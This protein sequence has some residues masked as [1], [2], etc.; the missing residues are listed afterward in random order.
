MPLTDLLDE[1]LRAAGPSGYEDAVTAIV[2]R[3]AA[4]LGAEVETDVL[5]S[6]VV[7][8]RGT[9]GGR[10]L[11]LFAHIDQV[12]FAVRDAG[13]D[14]LLTVAKLANWS[15][16]AA[17]RQRVRVL[18]ARGELAGVVT[19]VG[20]GDL[21][22]D[23][24]R[25][26]VG[27]VDRAGALALVEPGDPVVLEGPPV[28]LAAGRVASAS[29]DDR[30]GLY[31]SFEALRRLAASPPAWDIA[32]VASTQEE[33]GTHG[34]AAAV[35]ARLR[36]DAAL[37]VDVTYAGDAPGGEKPWGDV[38]LG[39]GPAV[40]RGPVVSPLVVAGLLSAAAEADIAVSVEAGQSTWSDADDVFVVGGGV[41]TGMICIPLR[42]MHTAGEVAQLSDI[43]A[44]SRLIEAYARSLSPDASFLR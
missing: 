39:G 36:P 22:W 5:G 23:D 25:L 41:P 33:T 11:A 42:Y 6:T 43:D 35:A 18:T 2:R 12:S 19:R 16:E 34:G 20:A 38:K 44:T 32:L 9:E 17:A 30:A 31:A 37:V 3:E 7:R 10:L 1:L 27:A 14:G 4:A 15:A 26:D 24:L 13:D 8:I 21:G 40:F 29:L 28:E